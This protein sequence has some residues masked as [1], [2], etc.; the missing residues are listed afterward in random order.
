MNEKINQ[1]LDNTSS[2]AL[3][4]SLETDK[5]YGAKKGR[6]ANNKAI[7]ANHEGNDH[8]KALNE[9]S[10]N[11]NSNSIPYESSSESSSSSSSSSST[12]SSSSS[13]S[14][15]DSDSTGYSSSLESPTSS[16]S[17]ST[18]SSS[19][20]S[21]DSDIAADEKEKIRK[22]NRKSTETSE[23]LSKTF[24]DKKSKKHQ[25]QRTRGNTQTSSI[26]EEGTALSGGAE[27]SMQ[28]DRD[29]SSS[30]SDV[31]KEMK[32]SKDHRSVSLPINKAKK[33]KVI[34]VDNRLPFVLEIDE[35]TDSDL[36]SVLQDFI[37]PV[38]MDLVNIEV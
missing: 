22:S 36:T 5:P 21:S 30:K 18:S 31:M 16:S 32:R 34:Y 6:K 13:S 11:N 15:S 28:R 4:L 14:D 19:S 29:K 1:S 27:D 20:S 24:S 10:Q 25:H 23:D 2:E 7:K 3:P 33:K 8:D 9:E 12:S 38:G 37:P 35:E 26:A 17:S